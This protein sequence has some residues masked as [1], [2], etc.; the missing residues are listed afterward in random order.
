MSSTG[1]LS[2]VSGSKGGPVSFALAGVCFFS[3]AKTLIDEIPFVF[4][5]EAN[6]RTSIINVDSLI[7]CIFGFVFFAVSVVFVIRGL[8]GN[9]I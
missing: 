1:Q 2:D 5:N 9:R 4:V 8:R 3:S 7:S 6:L